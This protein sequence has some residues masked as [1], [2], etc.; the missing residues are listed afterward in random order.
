MPYFVAICGNSGSGKTTLIEK[1]I[2]ALIQRGQKVSTLKHTSHT[3]HRL[4]DEGK[5]SD[6]H[7][8]AGAVSSVFWCPEQMMVKKRTQPD[9]FKEDVEPYFQD[10]DIVLVEGLHDSPWPENKIFVIQKVSPE[11]REFTLALQDRVMAVISENTEH[12]RIPRFSPTEVEPI[13]DFIIQKLYA[14]C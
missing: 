8:K 5:D 3:G 7:F 11:M 4:G 1:L 13:A 10:V 14:T 6:R 9:A 2:P 12:S